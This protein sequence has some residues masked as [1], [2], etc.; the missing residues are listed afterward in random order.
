MKATEDVWD[1]L[2]VLAA[3]VTRA[4]QSGYEPT[5]SR[6]EDVLYTLLALDMDYREFGA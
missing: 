6:T 5:V 4:I 1:M 2:F 3:E